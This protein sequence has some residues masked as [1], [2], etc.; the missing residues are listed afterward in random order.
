LRV[1][2]SWNGCYGVFN[3]FFTLHQFSN[4]LLIFE[5]QHLF[6]FQLN[7]YIKIFF[8]IYLFLKKNFGGDLFLT[9]SFTSQ[10]ATTP[11]FWKS[12]IKS[13][14]FKICYTPRLGILSYLIQVYTVQNTTFLFLQYARKIYF[15][16]KKEESLP[17]KSRGT[18]IIWNLGD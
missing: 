2:I 14:A 16:H 18:S 11:L 9:K 15:C 17:H 3:T 1:T 10:G 6:I 5:D 7:I 8:K 12:K 13:P 4:I